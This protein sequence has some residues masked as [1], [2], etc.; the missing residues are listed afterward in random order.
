MSYEI[1]KKSTTIVGALSLVGIIGF[2]ISGLPSS[3]LAAAA[4]KSAPASIVL[5]RDVLSFSE[6][7][8]KVGPAVVSI[9]VSRDPEMAAQMPVMP[10][11]FTRFF[12]KNFGF[13]FG[14]PGQRCRASRRKLRYRFRLL[15][16]P[17]VMW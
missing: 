17:K 16:M 11:P 13:Q 8:E 2:S 7:I 3:N 10:E 14:N 6:T 5:N 4:I 9:R 12:G 15:S 1:F